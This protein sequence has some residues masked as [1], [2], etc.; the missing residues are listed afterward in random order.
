MQ[1]ELDARQSVQADFAETL[2]ALL[3]APLAGNP[4]DFSLDHLFGARQVLSIHSDSIGRSSRTSPS[5]R[6][7][8]ADDGGWTPGLVKDKGQEIL[9]DG[10][11][12]RIDRWSAV[13]RRLNLFV[14]EENW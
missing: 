3:S 1:L 5:R 6:S 12:Q 10:F 11:P 7:R 9:A 14:R 13:Y 4:R 2:S 8:R